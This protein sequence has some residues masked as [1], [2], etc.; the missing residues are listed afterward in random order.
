MLQRKVPSALE[1]RRGAKQAPCCSAP[2]VLSSTQEYDFDLGIGLA[3][4][5]NKV[6]YLWHITEAL[7]LKTYWDKAGCAFCLRVN[8]SIFFC[9]PRDW[10]C[11]QNFTSDLL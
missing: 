8:T 7:H 3:D 9:F 1:V 2:A 5:L 10:K 4:E 11:T 6:R